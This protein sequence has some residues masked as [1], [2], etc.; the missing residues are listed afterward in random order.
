MTDDGRD[1]G[2]SSPEG[3]EH[4]KP[5]QKRS[6]RV[7]IDGWINLDKPPGVA[8]TQ[9][10][11]R[12]KF[13]FNAKKAGHAGTLDPLAS[14]VLPIAFGEATKTVSIVQDGAKSYRFTVK[15]GEETDTD[16][17]E[18]RVIATSDARPS[19]AAIEA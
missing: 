18:G 1:G 6:S 4:E 15:W 16:D 3:R 11:G 12:L 19:A 7:E 5:R 13:L 17:S 2:L 10:V 8:S 9:A 14:G